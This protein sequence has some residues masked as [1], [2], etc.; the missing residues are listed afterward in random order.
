MEEF[1]EVE[2]MWIK[3]EEFNRMED[4]CIFIRMFNLYGTQ[5]ITLRDDDKIFDVGYYEDHD[6][7]TVFIEYVKRR[8]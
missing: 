5:W 7:N 6:D 8:V 4:K 3:E 1:K 2:K